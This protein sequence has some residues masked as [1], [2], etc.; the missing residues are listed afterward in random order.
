MIIHTAEWHCEI[1]ISLICIQSSLFP[2]MEALSLNWDCHLPR[3][4]KDAGYVG[5]DLPHKANETHQNEHLF[6]V[7][8][9]CGS[10]TGPQT[11]PF[12][13]VTLGLAWHDWL[14]SS[15]L[16]VRART[17]SKEWLNGFS[18]DWI[19]DAHKMAY[20]YVKQSCSGNGRI[21]GRL[22]RQCR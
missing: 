7:Q 4:G 16:T 14:K 15:G 17:S 13:N 20:D 2:W 21:S 3:M 5:S 6:R 10:F 1:Q 9:D 22:G 11:E 18:Q 12:C 8:R 19:N